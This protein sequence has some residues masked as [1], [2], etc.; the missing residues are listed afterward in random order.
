[1]GR[2]GHRSEMG[3]RAYKRGN[4]EIAR[5]VSK[6]LNHPEPKL[7]K[8]DPEDVPGFLLNISYKM[9]V[10]DKWKFWV[11]PV[12][13]AY[14]ITALSFQSIL[15]IDVHVSMFWGYPIAFQLKKKNLLFQLQKHCLYIKFKKKV[16]C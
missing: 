14:L 8:N 3:V 5:T 15:G 9:N 6:L 1:M 11:R 12:V 4:A 2:T 16:K 10:S 13:A 7:P